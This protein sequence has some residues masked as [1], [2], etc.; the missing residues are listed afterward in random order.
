MLEMVPLFY[1]YYA[2][3]WA[4]ETL[5]NMVLA[6]KRFKDDF[7]TTYLEYFLN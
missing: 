4:Q 3:N 2:T 5:S 6:D 1:N 7:M